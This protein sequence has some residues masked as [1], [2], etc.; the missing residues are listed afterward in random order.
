[1][2]KGTNARDH[3]SKFNMCIAQLLG[4][5]IKIDEEDQTIILLNHYR[6]HMRHWWLYFQLK[7]NV[8]DHISKFNKCIT[9]LLL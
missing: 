4:V 7:D 1:M 2:D 9:Q 3:I 5:E 6:N 8:R